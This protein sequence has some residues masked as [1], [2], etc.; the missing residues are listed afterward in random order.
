M[1][2]NSVLEVHPVKMDMGQQLYVNIKVIT[3]YF[4]DKRMHPS[5]DTLNNQFINSTIDELDQ[6]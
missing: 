2:I 3:N 5:I 6:R 4:I 1:I